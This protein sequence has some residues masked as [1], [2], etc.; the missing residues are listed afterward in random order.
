MSSL[1]FWQKITE[2]LV[3]VME[4]EL[5]IK[6]ARN[7]SLELQLEIAGKHSREACVLG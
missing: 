6:V 4:A 3:S 5:D 2:E 1:W 7:N